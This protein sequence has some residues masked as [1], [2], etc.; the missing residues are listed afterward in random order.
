MVFDGC[1]RKISSLLYT[2]VGRYDR[3]QLGPK[4]HSF[5][6]AL[7]QLEDRINP[8]DIRWTGGANGMGFEWDDP[9]NWTPNLVPGAIRNR[10]DDVSIP[11]G[12]PMITAADG[13]MPANPALRSITI[14]VAGG[15]EIWDN[16]LLVDDDAVLRN[17]RLHRDGAI[18]AGGM[19]SLVGDGNVIGLRATLRGANV[20]ISGDVLLRGGTITAG[21]QGVIEIRGSITGFGT[22]NAPSVNNAGTIDVA[23]APPN[24]QANQGSQLDQTSIVVLGDYSNSAIDVGT[25]T[26]IF[27]L[28]D[29][30]RVPNSRLVVRGAANL[31]G[32]V[33]IQGPGT[34]RLPMLN[35]STTRAERLSLTNRRFA[36]FP[37][38]TALRQCCGA[39]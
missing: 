21:N 23:P 34:A 20:S 4:R 7:E 30:S 8:V 28:Y 12:R 9:Q 14:G 25:G 24:P 38:V 22:L 27:H 18:L 29:N 5:H 1:F 16:T 10:F 39:I 31:A 36:G 19:V 13:R 37:R 33:D 35:S 11:S 17:T 2:F 26:L 3:P 15:L 32:T 6:C